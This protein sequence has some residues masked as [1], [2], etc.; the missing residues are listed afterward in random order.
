MN[1]GWF[2]AENHSPKETGNYHFTLKWTLE[3]EACKESPASS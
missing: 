1:P 2:P 3:A